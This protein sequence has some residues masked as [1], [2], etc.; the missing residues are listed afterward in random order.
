MAGDG[1]PGERLVALLDKQ[2]GRVASRGPA[3]CL[4]AGGMPWRH[5]D[6]FDRLLAATAIHYDVPLIAA[7]VAFDGIVQR[8]R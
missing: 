3:I 8:I 6:P 7:D 5:R 1:R 4:A 2:G